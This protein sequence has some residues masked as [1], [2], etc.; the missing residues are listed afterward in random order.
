MKSFSFKI[1]VTNPIRFGYMHLMSLF[2]KNSR[3]RKRIVESRLWDIDYYRQQVVGGDTMSEITLL[4]HYLGKGWKLGYDPSER[5]CSDA[6]CDQ[7]YWDNGFSYSPLEHYLFWGYRHNCVPLKVQDYKAIVRGDKYQQWI[8]WAKN[9]EKP[10]L[11]ISHEYSN[12]GAPIA[13]LWMAE[14]MKKMGMSPLMVSLT[15][16][17]LQE[18]I[19]KKGIENI[20]ASLIP[21]RYRVRKNKESQCIKQFLE[22]FDFVVFNCIIG[23]CWAADMPKVDKPCVCWIH[24]GPNAMRNPFVVD[25]LVESISRMSLV[26]SV[27]QFTTDAFAPHCDKSIDFRLFP[28]GINDI[29]ES[30]EERKERCIRDGVVR[31]LMPGQITKRKGHHTLL[32]AMELIPEEYRKRCEIIVAGPSSAAENSLH[33][34]VM[35]WAARSENVDY[36]GELCHDDFV[37][38][39]DEV[40]VVLCPSL[41]DPLPIVCAEALSKGKA[42]IVSDRTGTAS[43]IKDKETGYIVKS[44]N[45]N[46]LK[47]AICYAIDNPS[48]VCIIGKRGRKVF[49]DIFN[50][51]AFDRRVE[52]LVNDVYSLG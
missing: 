29:N 46:S 51:D 48:E 52:E 43:L 5:F 34:R 10:V 19:T 35:D 15:S 7:Y 22:A 8:D 14:S 31:F 4:R 47:D 18:E 32:D 1:L 24:D 49:E 23:L 38:L 28:Y 42:I 16:G 44:G 36:R 27:S 3:W 33:K 30:I 17:N 21:P 11:L 20:V 25:R 45:V 40:D 39:Y 12:T 41:E 50:V 2:V 37:K 26:Y 6:Y 13:L 9:H